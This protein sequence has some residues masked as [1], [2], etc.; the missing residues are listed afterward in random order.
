MTS[1]L[2]PLRETRGPRASSDA[3]MAAIRDRIADGK[4]QSEREPAADTAMPAGSA[5]RT[6][7]DSLVRARPHS[8]YNLARPTDRVMQPG[9]LVLTDIGARHRGYVADGGRGFTYSPASAE[10]KAIFAA[11]GRAVESG[12]ADRS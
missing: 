6:G 12:R 3:V 2:Q 7:Y 9:D 8:R 5:D 1:S 11:A 10:N 4:P